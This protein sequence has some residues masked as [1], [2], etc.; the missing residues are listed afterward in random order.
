MGASYTNYTIK[1]AAHADVVEYFS[2]R[3]AIVTPPDKGCIVVF[4]QLSDRQDP[5]VIEP[6]GRGLSAKLGCVVLSLIVHD[7][8]IL[9]YEL[10][11][12]GK[13]IDEYNSNPSYFDFSATEIA[14]PAGGNVSVLCEAFGVQNAD[15]VHQV[16]H[17]GAD[18]YVFA[19]D[20]H[21]DLVDALEIS[22]YSVGFSHQII[23]FDYYP[24]GLSED[25]ITRLS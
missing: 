13:V 7:D 12:D 11:Q 2:G 23:G 24:D 5:S 14:P 21:K 19:S 6:L 9:A 15:Q 10:I 1:G 18:E 22:R 17:S 16:L 8:D 4:D 20:H 3:Q 25:A